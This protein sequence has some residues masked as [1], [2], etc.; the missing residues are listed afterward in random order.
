MLD[1]E[2]WQILLPHLTESLQEIK[3][4]RQG[5]GSTIEEARAA[6]FGKAALDC[7]FDLTGYRETDPDRLWRYKR[8]DYG[9]PCQSCGKPLR[10][11][12]ARRCVE[13]GA[14]VKSGVHVAE[15][16]L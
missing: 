7:Y 8:S 13:C 12:T 9:A 16:E 15:G 5:H 6:G 2:E 11:Q 1:D 10:T 3:R 4:H 14:D